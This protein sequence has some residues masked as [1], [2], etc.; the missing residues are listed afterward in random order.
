MSIY[1]NK[2]RNRIVRWRLAF[3][4]E[5]QHVTGVLGCTV[6][7]EGISWFLLVCHPYCPMV[8]CAGWFPQYL[9]WFLVN[10]DWFPI[11]YRLYCPWL[12]VW[13]GSHVCGRFPR[14]PQSPQ[15]LQGGVGCVW[16][17]GQSAPL[18][19]SDQLVTCSMCCVCMC[20]I[21][22]LIYYIGLC[23]SVVSL[24][25]FLSVLFFFIY[26]F[27]LY[28]NSFSV[29]NELMQKKTVHHDVCIVLFTVQILLF[30]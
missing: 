9:R 30:L 11:A 16:Y 12:I 14:V 6:F 24:I 23:S 18:S 22:L 2:G 29:H 5:A 8:D 1:I 17:P 7:T 20:G 25:I 4:A 15:I 10:V 26:F 13:F 3:I 21:Q 19:V 28:F 27:Y